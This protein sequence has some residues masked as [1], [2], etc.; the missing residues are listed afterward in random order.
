MCSHISSFSP[1]S[2]FHNTG[3]AASLFSHFFLL[4]AVYMWESESQTA[5]GAKTPWSVQTTDAIEK[6]GWYWHQ[7]IG[8]YL[9]VMESEMDSYRLPI[10]VDIVGSLLQP[11]VSGGAR[12][13]ANCQFGVWVLQFFW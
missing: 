9:V 2:H 7:V 6:R 8:F 10:W 3:D 5:L 1:H 11:H 12:G 4:L 13:L